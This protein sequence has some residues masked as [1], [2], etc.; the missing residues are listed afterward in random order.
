MPEAA[1]TLTELNPLTTR[2]TDEQH[3]RDPGFHAAAFRYREER[4]TRSVSQRLQRL[5]QDDPDGFEAMN[6]VQDHLV[7]LARAHVER[8]VNE[9][10]RALVNAQPEGPARAALATVADLFALS[11]LEAGRGWYLEAGYMEG[12]KTRAIRDLVNRL[13]AEVATVAVPLVDGFGIPD[14]CLDA[15]I[16]TANSAET[17]FGTLRTP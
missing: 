17:N 12:G 10:F 4:L 11:R 15:P 3:L 9:Q 5:L 6:S 13:C 14:A 1:V 8:V 7:L 16:A 2:L